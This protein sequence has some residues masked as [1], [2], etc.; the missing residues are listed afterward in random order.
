MDRDTG[1]LAAELAS[2]SPFDSLAQPALMQMA[3]QSRLESYAPGELVVDAFRS[4]QGVVYVVL[5]GRVGLWNDP[6]ELAG[7][8]DEMLGPGGVFG[9]SALLTGRPVGPRAVAATAAR[10]VL[11]PSSAAMTAFTS[12]TGA[13][14][15]AEH[16]LGPRTQGHAGG[17]STFSL[18]GELVARPP[19][20]L[21]AA[22]TVQQAAAAM[23]AA[24]VSSAVLGQA[25]PLELAVVTDGSLRRQ[26][27]ALGLDPSTPASEARDTTV[28]V[29]DE[30]DSLAEAAIAIID[31]HA[32][33]VA[34][35]R[36]N[37]TLR[38]IVAMRDIALVTTGDLALHAGLRRART[39]AHLVQLA[40][41]IPEVLSD[42]VERGVAVATVV[43]ML[44]KL[45]D[46]MT[47]RALALVLERDPRLTDAH[48]T[49][50]LLGSC[51][52]REA[53]LS[54]DID[55]GAVFT[56]GCPVEL[57][58][59]YRT[60]FAQVHDILA[61]AGWPGDP[62][63]TTASNPAYSRTAADLA[64]A[65]SAW[66]ADPTKDK[67][68]IMTSLLVDSRAIYGDPGLAETNGLIADLRARP[69]TMRLLLTESLSQA[70][71]ATHAKV[72]LLRR[73]GVID[74]KRDAVLP[75]VNIARWAAL[76]VG[77]DE[78]A[79][80][81]RLRAASGTTMMPRQEG[82]RLVEV[83]T[84]LQRV[85]MRQHLTQVAAGQRP[86]DVVAV[87]AVSPLDR[88]LVAEAVREI[89]AVRRRMANIAQFV[90]PREWSTDEGS[91]PT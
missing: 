29:V 35:R 49:W 41:G 19:V 42:L 80:P 36:R 5:E 28:P 77:S 38:G 74:L 8:S 48:F 76:N 6:D 52:R 78:L 73:P 66:A 24:R 65:T 63:G 2:I 9:F 33:H 14:F 37:G 60:A 71:R 18:I 50:V 3:G 47:R 16:I 7:P 39:P 53:L 51:G 55:S 89:N 58:A 61:E 83:F 34:V 70:A 4:P 64:V 85:R 46:A 13:Q 81:A 62:H 25:T 59:T 15:L 86:T 31:A 67:G 57:M 79:T 10:L 91:A 26:V 17:R 87:D 90:E 45:I 12:T 27:L 32:A 68:A 1:S 43:S 11:V 20:V 56:P 23:T 82:E 40:H 88:S 54:S 75:V 21:D 22:A 30:D 84:A 72:G 44:S 69:G